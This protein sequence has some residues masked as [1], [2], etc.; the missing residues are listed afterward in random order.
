MQDH[1]RLE[2]HKTV[3]VKLPNFRELDFST[4]VKLSLFTCVLYTCNSFVIP[5]TDQHKCLE[6]TPKFQMSTFRIVLEKDPSFSLIK[7]LSIL[8]KDKKGKEMFC[9]LNHHLLGPLHTTANTYQLY[10]ISWKHTAVGWIF[11]LTLR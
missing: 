11:S 10:F 4:S 6:D 1:K 2:L 3:F 7:S 9:L 5:R 8:C